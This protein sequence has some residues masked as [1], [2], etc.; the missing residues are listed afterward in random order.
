[1]LDH[2]KD[3]TDEIPDNIG[4]KEQ[5]QTGQ[6]FF[7]ELCGGVYCSACTVG[8]LFPDWKYLFRLCRFW[9]RRVISD[10]T[11]WNVGLFYS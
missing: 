9:R 7:V 6:N 2:Q 4:M 1:M 5:P 8:H 11:F 10:F 3:I